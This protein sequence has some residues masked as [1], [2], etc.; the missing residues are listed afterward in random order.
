MS[1]PLKSA[2]TLVVILALFAVFW[3]V[4]A[5]FELLTPQTLQH[6]L[7]WVDPSALSVWLLLPLVMVSYA[8]ALLV[9][10]PLTLLVVCTGLLF[11]PIWGLVYATAGT[12]TSSVLSYWVGHYM[13]RDAVSRPAGDRLQKVSR[14]LSDRGVRTMVII[15]LLPVAPFTLTNMLAGAFNLTFSH[16]MLGSALGIIPGLAAVTV[17]GSQLRRVLMSTE[18]EELAHPGLIIA[19][20]FIALIIVVLWLKRYLT[21]SPKR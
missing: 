5:H 9:M 11:G 13:G 6:W 7:N 19:G 1:G 10:V 17:A 16:Y 4:L 12:L 2:L 21:K 8:L 18:L 3:R 20:S 14:Y 15:N